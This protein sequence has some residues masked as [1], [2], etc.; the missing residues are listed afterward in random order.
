VRSSP[1]AGESTQSGRPG[2]NH[3]AAAGSTE[4]SGCERRNS[5][6]L[7]SFSCGRKGAGRIDEPPAGPQHP[8]GRLEDLPLAA[9]AHPD[10]L[11]APVLHG[12]VLLAEHA[13]AR[14]GRV[15][16]NLV[17]PTGEARLEPLRVLVQHE[18]VRR[19]Q[20]LEIAGEDLCA[21]GLDLVADENA[22][23][24]HRGGQLR[25]LAARGG[26]EIEHALA[27]LRVQK[28]GRGHRARLLQVVEPGLVQG[29]EPRARVGVVIKPVPRPGDGGQA[30]LV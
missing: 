4:K 19:A 22:P 5:L 18:R 9:G 25:A 11:L 23:A 2:A 12:G 15:D 14:A 7:P 1:G 28:P 6:T 3:G 27:R 10:G 17:E 30:M 21:G 26:A 20:A 8:R 13:L 24:P 16:E 29:R